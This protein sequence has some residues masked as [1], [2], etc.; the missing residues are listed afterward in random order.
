[1]TTDEIIDHLYDL[2][3]EEF[4]SARND[5]ERTLRKEGKRAE[6]ARVKELRKPT[7]AAAAVN[8]LV[9]QH[10]KDVERFLAAADAL[11]QAQLAG[12]GDLATATQHER[13]ALSRLVRAGGEHVRQS[14]QAAAVDKEAAG[15]LLE[16]R[17]QQELEP[18][19]FGS[20]LTGAP[21]PRSQPRKQPKPPVPPKQNNRAARAKLREARE[22]LTE[23]RARER[24][25]HKDWK[26][27]EADVKKAEAA[28][29]RA[30]ESLAAL[31][32]TSAR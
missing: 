20:L 14:L 31:G 16:A 15:R 32:S 8:R 29:A 6:A 12:K 27:A 1:L 4:T 10:R 30:E 5:A 3:P 19:G 2:P 22:A 9:R 21:R 18:G 11:R 23:S 7:A 28:V 26:R 24:S 17:L 13:D 25:A